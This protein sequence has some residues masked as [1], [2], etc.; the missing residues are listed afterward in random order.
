MA[1]Q[2]KYLHPNV[3]QIKDIE[4]FGGDEEEYETLWTGVGD[5][6]FDTI[7]EFLEAVPK[8]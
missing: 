7:K 1:Q 4:M 3:K 8:P 5:K 6:S 2:E